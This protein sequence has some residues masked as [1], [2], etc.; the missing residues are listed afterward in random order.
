MET[1]YLTRCKVAPFVPADFRGMPYESSS[2]LVSS[3][4]HAAACRITTIPLGECA[5]IS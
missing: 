3:R 4:R 5:T 2:S 1:A